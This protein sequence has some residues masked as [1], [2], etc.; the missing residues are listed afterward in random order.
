MNLIFSK[1][2][3][4]MKVPRFTFCELCAFCMSVALIDMY[5]SELRSCHPL[6]RSCLG[7][8]FFYN[9]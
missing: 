3:F 7:Y 6:S 2:A 4:A 8:S 5:L 1:G 9:K